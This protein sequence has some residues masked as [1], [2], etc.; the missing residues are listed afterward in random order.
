M[1][2]RSRKRKH[3]N[4]PAASAASAARVRASRGAG[5]PVAWWRDV[6][7]WAAMSTVLVLVGHSLGAP[8]GEP[9]AEDFDF[10]HRAL[11]GANHTLLDGGGSVAFW[12][13]VSHQLYYLALGRVMLA[14]PRVVAALHAL[15]MVVAVWLVYRGLRNTLSA[16]V[17]AV[18]AS[19]PVLAESTRTVLSWP[20]QFVD[21]GLWVFTAWAL[22][23]TSRGRLWRALLALVLALGSKELAVVAAVLL[24]WMPGQR[25]KSERMRWA[26]AMG[27]VAAVWAALYL[28][29]RHTTHLELPHHLEHSAE[30]AQATAVARYQWAWWNSVRAMM[31][32]PLI[33]TTYEG[34]LWL[35][36]GA[37]SVI[38][39]MVLGVRQAWRRRAEEWQWAAWGVAWFAMSSATLVVIYPLWQP[40]RSGYGSLGAG[41]AAAVLLELASPVLLALLVAVRMVAFAAAPGPMAQVW[42][43]APETGA[44]MDFNQLVRLQKLMEAVRVRLERSFPKLP[45]SSLI[46]QND[47]PLRSEYAFGGS[48]ALQCWYRDSTVRWVRFDRFQADTALKPVTIVQ[49]QPG[50]E[51]MV[52]LADPAAMR[53]L[54]NCA[55]PLAAEN[56]RETL[57]M[58]DRA[59]SLQTDKEARV[60][61]AMMQV[62]RSVAFAGLGRWQDAEHQAR[63]SM[64]DWPGNPAGRYWISFALYGQNR[65]S[66][67]AAELDTCFRERQPDSLSLGLQRAIQAQLARTGR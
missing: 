14:E 31:S 32:L 67:A 39:L 20:S 66:E 52:A 43:K 47:L 25:G 5:P 17:A 19:F 59:E 29:V 58:V 41:V 35:A 40:N 42:S 4:A 13:P 65:W 61:F 26:F 60:M 18:A 33:K 8:L 30:V 51:P 53:L 55:V 63:L 54:I 46:C 23:E 21:L 56:W 49:Y 44:F 1:P 37:L 9:V 15:L 34:S 10:L 62:R 24:P 27:G 2:P 57:E 11:L 6:W 45:P 50:H 7:C 64:V 22:Y 3:S 48:L 12:R 38:A 36:L 16:P 28:W